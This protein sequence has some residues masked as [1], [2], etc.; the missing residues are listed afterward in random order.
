MVMVAGGIFFFCLMGGPSVIGEELRP[1]YASAQGKIET[2][3]AERHSSRHGYYW[4]P[5]AVYS[6]E[7]AGQMHRG[8]DLC[9][10]AFDQPAFN[11]RSE[12]AAAQQFKVGSAV[13]VRYD[14]SD[15]EKCY[16]VVPGMEQQFGTRLG[17]WFVVV[18]NALALSIL[19]KTF[20]QFARRRGN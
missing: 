18:W 9:E 17:F 16:L 10:R 1:P 11:K 20:V 12:Q 14:P 7:V 5:K 3:S 8:S 13:D 15:P 19:V 6:F 2:L 4:S